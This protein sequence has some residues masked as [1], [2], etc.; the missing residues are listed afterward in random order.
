MDIINTVALAPLT[1]LASASA[2]AAAAAPNAM[3]AARFAE[4]MALPPDANVAADAV[5]A[6]GGAASPLQST[7][8]LPALDADASVGDRIL[9]GLQ[10]VSGEFK[11]SWSEVSKA[12]TASSGDTM[13]MQDIL[14]LQLHLVQT[15]FQYEMVGKVISRSTQ[16]LDQ[17]VRIQ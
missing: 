6:S 2:P 12:V 1:N 11:T 16:N 17:L 3:A 14:K 13:N 4:L 10:S 7:N 5:Q 9:N 8:A 15:S